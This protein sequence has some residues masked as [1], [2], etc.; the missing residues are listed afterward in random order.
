MK[1]LVLGASGS[2]GEQTLDIISSN[3]NDF[4]LVGFSVGNNVKVLK[5]I[6]KKFPSVKYVC[7]KN[8]KDYLLLKK[9]YIN[10][11][12]YYGDGGL[13]SLINNAQPEMVVN[14]LVGFVG[15]SPTIYSLEN[16]IDVAIANKESIVVGGELI[17][18]ILKTSKA[19][20][21][22]IDSEHVALAKCL[23]GNNKN[24]AKLILTASGGA[25]RNLDRDELKNVTKEDALKHPS[26]SMGEKITIDCATMMNKGFEVIE[27]HYLFNVEPEKIDILM[28]DESKVH[29]LILLDDGSYIA[30]IGPSD[31][32]IPIS[33]ALYKNERVNTNIRLPLEDFG[34]FHFHK[35]NPNRYPCVGFALKALKQGGTMLAC[36]NASNEIAVNAFLRKEIKFLDIEKVIETSCKRHRVISNPTLED[37]VYA[38]KISREESLRIIKEELQ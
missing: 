9:K 37:L 14:A 31:M 13:I 15:L 26:W 2:I 7:V 32:R 27:A 1:I 21:Y 6:L 23:K 12:F 25:F 34:N 30:D 10:I 18:N 19:K 35:F 22:P 33:Y 11:S 29:S 36:L 24:V 17:N 16:N 38:D 28:H 20:L 5:K 8:E 3:T 4:E